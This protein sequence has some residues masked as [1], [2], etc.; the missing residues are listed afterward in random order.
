MLGGETHGT[1]SAKCFL[2]VL[3]LVEIL[4]HILCGGGR[5]I[6]SAG[7]RV[8][9]GDVGFI[10]AGLATGQRCCDRQEE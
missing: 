8:G 7:V 6:A 3:V 4:G 10:G 5:R 2:N 1:A 9:P